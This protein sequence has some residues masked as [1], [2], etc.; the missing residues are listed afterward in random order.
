[1]LGCKVAKTP[2]EPKKRG[3]EESPTGDKD[4]CQSLV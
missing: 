4:R 1:M 3:E 2:I